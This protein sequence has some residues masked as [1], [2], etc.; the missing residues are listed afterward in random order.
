MITFIITGDCDVQIAPG[1]FFQAFH[2]FVNRVEHSV[3]GLVE[4]VDDLAV[5]TFVPGGVC[6]GVK[7]A[8]YGRLNQFLRIFEQ[9]P[10]G[11]DH[12]NTGGH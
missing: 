6:P 8:V 7:L 2:R 12:M 10:D 4:T 3:K 5:L 1:H 11:L 9:V